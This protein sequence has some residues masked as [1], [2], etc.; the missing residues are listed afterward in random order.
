MRGVFRLLMLALMLTAASGLRLVVGSTRANTVSRAA[1]ACMAMPKLEDARSLSTEEIQQEIATA[2]KVR[3]APP[4]PTKPASPHARTIGPAPTPLRPGA[5]SSV[6]PGCTH[7]DVAPSF[8][9]VQELFE[10]R[11]KVKTRQQVKPHLFT[12]TKH[13]IGQLETLLSQR[14]A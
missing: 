13:R 2:K 10:L 1:H 7:P 12:H 3:R 8:L 5:S 11:K 14:A 9:C 6:H 4:P